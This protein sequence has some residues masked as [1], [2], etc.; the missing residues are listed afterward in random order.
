[1]P[2]PAELRHLTAPALL[3]QHFT[4][5][6]VGRG[7]REEVSRVAQRIHHLLHLRLLGLKREDSEYKDSGTAHYPKCTGS[8]LEH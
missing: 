6:E 4:R 3:I 5:I 7:A 8:I 2:V 1:M